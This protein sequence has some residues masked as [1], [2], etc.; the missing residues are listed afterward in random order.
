[1][2]SLQRHIDAHHQRG[3]SLSEVLVTVVILS[4]GLL[5][6]AGLQLT[7]LR[8]NG[9]AESRTAATWHA[10]DFADRM[11][12]NLTGASAGNYD[13]VVGNETDPGC[14]ATGCTAAE[15]AQYDK[16]AWLQ[17]IGNDPVLL[18]GTGRVTEDDGVFTVTVM[19]DESRTGATGTD[20]GADETVDMKC[21]AIEVEL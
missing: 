4:I 18:S 5:G 17:N 11:R 9:Q 16:W 20:C 14:I 19:W 8:A 13:T 2:K 21:L 15:L 3:T 10:Y 7:G 1:M 6:L 12:A